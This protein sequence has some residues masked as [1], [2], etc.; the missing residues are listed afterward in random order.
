MS[1]LYAVVGNPIAQSKSPVIHSMFAEACGHRITYERIESPLGRFAETVNAFRARGG[2]GINITAPFKLDAVAYATEKSTA[3]K[4]AGAA[5]AI[6]FDGSNSVAEN[7]D[8]V[9]LVRDIVANLRT[10]LRG[11]RILLLGAGGASRGALSPILGELPREV[12]IANRDVAKAQALVTDVVGAANSNVRACG[13]DSLGEGAFD[14]VLNA[15]SSSLAH[16]LPPIEAKLFAGS[17][18][19]YDLTYGKGL[20]PFLRLAKESGA[21]QWVDG[22]GMLVEQAAEAFYWWRGVRPA[23]AQAIQHLTVPLN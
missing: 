13:Y 14:V 16:A 18:L 12:W 7:F 19:A 22:V 17:R 23:T 6:K 1:D 4:I 2:A 10:P 9:G 15:T 5:N 20:T 3:A 21:A 11:K 8:G